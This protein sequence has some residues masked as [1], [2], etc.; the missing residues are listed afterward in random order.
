MDRVDLLA[1]AILVQ[2]VDDWDNS[3]DRAEITK[4]IYSERFFGL[5]ELSDCDETDAKSICAKLQVGDYDPLKIRAYYRKK[6]R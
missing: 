3:I 5:A 2:M 6:R 1:E 4:F